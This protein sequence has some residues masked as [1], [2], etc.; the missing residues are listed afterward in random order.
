MNENVNLQTHH[1][2]W[3]ME[4]SGQNEWHILPRGIKIDST[5]RTTW[6]WQ[7]ASNR[8]AGCNLSKGR[9][10]GQAETIAVQHIPFIQIPR[11]N[12]QTNV[13]GVVRDDG[14][15]FK[16]VCIYYPRLTAKSH[17]DSH[18]SFIDKHT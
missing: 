6:N 15:D 7:W 1:C 10:A 11:K 13:K 8:K 12:L 17:C 2:D 5:A 4:F 16:A 14:I 9:N 18:A 3:K